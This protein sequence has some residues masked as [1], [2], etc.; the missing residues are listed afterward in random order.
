MSAKKW[1]VVYIAFLFLFVSIIGVINYI[2]DPHWSFSHKNS[3]NQ[4]QFPFNE[5]QQKSNMVYFSGLKRYDGLLIGSS[6]TTFINQNDFYN[7]NIYNYAL[8]SIYP[9]EYERYIEF[10]KESHGGDF[11]YIIIGADFY[12]TKKPKDIKF[13]NPDH[14]ISNT[15]RFL[16]RYIMLFSLDTL[17]KSIENIEANISKKS[18]IYYSRNN[19]K[20]RPRVSEN[21]RIRAYKKHLKIHI[22]SFLVEN[23]QKNPDYIGILKRLK[24]SNPNT[25]FIIFTS[26]ISANLLVS[27][28]KKGDRLEDFKSWL[29]DMVNI[30]GEVHH[31]MTI[32]SITKNLQ[33]YPDDDHFYP[34]IGKLLANKISNR[35]NIN[36]PNDF[37]IVLT[38]N[39]IDRYLKSFE[40]ELEK[41]KIKE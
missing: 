3:L 18:P 7:M 25:K 32:N 22:D 24:K 14:Y 5:R 4:F 16:Y 11:K 36:I 41:F 28:I 8:D 12:N 27:M 6:R 34:Y 39:N 40:K 20:F 17:K 35:K 37:G 21:E 1:I 10:A 2:I 19:I 26:P 29:K 23:Y 30:F 33:N 9:F 15:K 38:K 31:F 13:K